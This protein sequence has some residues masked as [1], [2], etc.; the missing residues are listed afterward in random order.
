MVM[1]QSAL[2][3]KNHGS[4]VIWLAGLPLGQRGI[5]RHTVLGEVYEAAC[6]LL[7]QLVR[8]PGHIADNH[9]VRGVE[10][11]GDIRTVPGGLAVVIGELEVEAVAV[12]SGL[13][14]K[15]LEASRLMV[16]RTSTS[17]RFFSG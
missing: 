10:E 15:S 1:A 7:L 13:R 16:S 11:E 14:A 3:V 9:L 17:V 12:G 4:H 6:H 2:P 5:I 8:D